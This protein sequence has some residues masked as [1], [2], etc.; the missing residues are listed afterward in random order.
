MTHEKVGQAIV[1]D[2]LVLQDKWLTLHTD[3]MHHDGQVFNHCIQLLHIKLQVHKEQ[4]L[5]A[6]LR[7][8]GFNL[9]WV[10]VDLQSALWMLVTK[11][12][13]VS[14]DVRGAGD[15]MPKVDT[16][17][18]RIKEQFRSN[19]GGLARNL[20]PNLVKDLVAY[21]VSRINSIRSASINQSIAPK[22]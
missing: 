4:E 7:S 12:E 19:K 1:D 2:D 11:F 8:K 18:Q 17:I 14:M 10:Y 16:K 13:N 20:P 15:Y 3:I 22:V 21:A 5:Q 6:V 9:I